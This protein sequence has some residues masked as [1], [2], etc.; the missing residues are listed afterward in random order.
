MA[1]SF[2]RTERR[3]LESFQGQHGAFNGLWDAVVVDDA[4]P[5]QQGRVRVRVLDLHDDDTPVESLPWA[6]P[7]FPAAFTNKSNPDISGGFFHVPP[8]DALVAVMFR[9]GDPEFPVWMG[10]WFP[11][12]PAI[13]GRE[14]Y[15][16]GVKR[17]A[18]YAA[19]GKPRCPTWR[20]LRGH[21][22]ELDDDNSE[23]RITSPGGHKVTLSDESGNEHGDCIK[24]EDRKGNFIWMNTGRDLL[25]IFWNGDVDEQI[26]GNKSMRISGDLNIQVD[27]DLGE[28]I[29]GKRDA[30]V[31]GDAAIDT[32]G[33][34]Y[35]NSL[36]AAPGPAN[37]V[38]PGES[39]AGDSVGI[40]SRLGN[41]IRKILTG[42]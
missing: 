38:P 26:N 19:D 35:L 39:A 37:A 13:T 16:D 4:D 41:Q 18:L 9:R 29:G 23:M 5:E 6:S 24:L 32:G 12:A 1:D 20:S 14:G 27:G 30:Q 17:Q 28:T 15:T 42:G 10:G 11:Q 36:K 2:G 25:Q 31:S 21:I 22:I 8:I 40:L 3:N 7:C 33:I 34:L